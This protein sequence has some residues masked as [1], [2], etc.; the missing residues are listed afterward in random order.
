MGDNEGLI[1]MCSR[2]D[3]MWEIWKEA[4]DGDAICWEKSSQLP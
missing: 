3:L 2:T 4:D 1:V